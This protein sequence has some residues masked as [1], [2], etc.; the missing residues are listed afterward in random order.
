MRS[1]G[2]KEVKSQ[3]KKTTLTQWG[4]RFLFVLAMWF[5]SRV[6]IAIAMQFI[7][8]LLPAS[9][10]LRQH[11]QTDFILPSLGWEVFSHF[12]G[13]WYRQI[14][15]LGYEYQNGIWGDSVAFFPF[16]P[17]LVRAVMSIGLPFEVAGTLVNNLAFLGAL[18]VVYFWV[19][20]CYGR[21]TAKWATAV[22]AWCPFSLFG[23]VTYTEGL[24][25]LLSTAALRA[26]D[27]RKYAWAALWGALTT[28]TRLNGIALIPAF[29]IV[30]W[31][32]RR[33]FSA[34]VAGLATSGGLI[35]FSLYCAFRSGDPLAFVNAQQ[36]WHPQVG[37]NWQ[38]WWELFTRELTFAEGW[39][40]AFRA[41][42]RIVTFFGGGYLL[43]HFRAKLRYVAV[44]YG[45]CAIGLIIGSGA[46]LSIDRY[47]YGIISISI[48][49]GMLLANHPRWRWAVMG[50]F[51]LLLVYFSLRFSW[52]LFVG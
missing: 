48:A 44:A 9:I 49:L 33:P 1:G 14:A 36:N 5:L 24:F 38:V 52:N 26:F 28:A 21:E 25:L 31:K 50:L 34:Y 30:A 22:L 10:M 19:E 27:N 12:D 6:A 3:M 23:T 41:S 7:A 46:I 13:N 15:T 37:G 32:E 8:P 4:N 40:T 45:F 11:H 51:A 39:S 18:G 16:Y 20:E 47:T 43:W 42:T 17:L 35:L 29:F 2:D